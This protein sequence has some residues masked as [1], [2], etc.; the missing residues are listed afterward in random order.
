MSSEEYNFILRNYKQ[1]FQKDINKLKKQKDDTFIINTRLYFL[2]VIL[3]IIGIGL[4]LYSY[5]HPE[6]VIFSV[7]YIVCSFLPQY[8]EVSVKLQRQIDELIELKNNVHQAYILG[9]AD[10][11]FIT[12][13][14]QQ[15]KNIITS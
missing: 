9:F 11:K 12:K 10:F 14:K 8:R 7:F 13:V 3:F 1:T 4:S 2:K 15:Y 6:L 5:F